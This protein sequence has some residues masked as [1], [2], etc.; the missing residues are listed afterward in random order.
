MEDN[1]SATLPGASQLN[2]SVGGDNVS[3]ETTELHVLINKEFGTKYTDDDA[4]LKGLKETRDYVGR[5][6]QMLKIVDVGRT[7]GMSETEIIQKMNESIN[8]NANASPVSE[9]TDKF[10]TKT[11]LL[12]L[13]R[14]LFYR[15]NPTLATYRQSIDAVADA[16]GKSPAEVVSMEQFKGLID[17]AKGFDEIQK[18]K[19]VLQTNPR[20]GVASDNLTKAQESA[21][22]G[23]IPGAQASAMK[24]VME[25]VYGQ[26]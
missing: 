24:A 18:A 4:A 19:S 10:A 11:E 25:V 21:K 22:A 23:D 9:G 17:S 5:A 1:Q 6:G 3:E 16:T 8:G 7:K 12:S 20:L 15:D 13:Q 26:K 14:D 2:A